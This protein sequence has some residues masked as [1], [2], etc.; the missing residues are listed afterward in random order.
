[1]YSRDQTKEA[2][3]WFP[4][5]ECCPWRLFCFRL[6]NF[7][8]NL[9][10]LL[11]WLDSRPAKGGSCD[12]KRDWKRNIAS[13]QTKSEE[14]RRRKKLDLERSGPKKQRQV[15]AKL[16]REKKKTWD[17]NIHV[18]LLLTK[19]LWRDFRSSSSLCLLKRVYSASQGYYACWPSPLTLL[20][21]TPF[22]L[23]QEWDIRPSIVPGT[24]NRGPWRNDDPHSWRLRAIHHPLAT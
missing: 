19:I 23:G 9:I 3:S 13:P 8:E 14:T 10:R 17:L 20:L 18:H 4:Q 16:V 24:I 5:V 6:Q 1:M 15:K 2:K 22:R 7:H 11:R 21:S 12:K